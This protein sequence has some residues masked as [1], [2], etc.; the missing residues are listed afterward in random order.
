MHSSIPI[1]PAATRDCYDAS[2]A[3]AFK[4]IEEPDMGSGT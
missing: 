3:A 2:S 1:R 4:E